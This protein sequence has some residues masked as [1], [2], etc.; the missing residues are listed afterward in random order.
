MVSNM[1]YFVLLLFA[2]ASTSAEYD[3]KIINGV[4][5]FIE[6]YPY[7][8]SI[9]MFGSHMCGGAI[10]DEDTILTAAHCMKL[11]KHAPMRWFLKIQAGSTRLYE[12]GQTISVS[13]IRDNSNYSSE[14]SD[15]DVAV[16]KLKYKLVFNDKVKPIDLP[17]ERPLPGTMAKAAGW[18]RT[19]A[20]GGVSQMLNAV[21]L[22]VI[23]QAI[24]VNSYPGKK[25][26]RKIVFS[27]IFFIKLLD[28]LVS[29]R[30]MCAGFLEGGK[31]TCQV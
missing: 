21:E 31:D 16:L 7:M 3:A 13:S 4:I 2:V 12:G 27:L 17:S 19:Q 9:Q 6:D 24:C 28:E 18:G 1:F 8:V 29:E 15:Y 30:M 26:L 23:D 20:G 14:V 11:A 22:P 5:S 10:L 25:L